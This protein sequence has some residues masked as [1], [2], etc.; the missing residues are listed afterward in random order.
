MTKDELISNVKEFVYEYKLS[1]EDVL[2]GAGGALLV[3]GMRD[4]TH[5]VDV[6]VPARFYNIYRKLKGVSIIQLHSKDTMVSKEALNHPL[7]PLMDVH[8]RKKDEEGFIMDGVY[9]YTPEYNLAFKTNMNRP[10][11]Q[12]DIAKLKDY[13]SKHGSN[14]E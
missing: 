2:V 7:F 9:I 5:D 13:I 3:M 6:S 4:S 10:K 11:D 14:K 12:A 1:T 8:L